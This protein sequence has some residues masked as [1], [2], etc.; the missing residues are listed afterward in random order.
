MGRVEPLYIYY[1][2]AAS[3]PHSST[4]VHLSRGRP[5]TKGRRG[6][7]ERAS[8]FLSSKAGWASDATANQHASRASH[9]AV[10]KAPS[11]QLASAESTSPA[12]SATHPRRAGGARQAATPPDAAMV[13]SH[14]RRARRGGSVRHGLQ[15]HALAGAAAPLGLFERPHERTPPARIRAHASLTPAYEIQCAATANGS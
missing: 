9:P 3:A 15:W 8:R 1:Y 14:R 11:T 13:V 4:V 5:T 7:A 2:A 10:I 6:L 12:S